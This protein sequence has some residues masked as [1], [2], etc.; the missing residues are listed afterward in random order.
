MT[1]MPTILIADDEQELCDSLRELLS[2]HGYDIHTANSG[3]EAI[4]S[5]NRIPYDLVLLDVLM[6]DIDGFRVME[7]IHRQSPG[8]LVI[9]ITGY[10]STESAIEALKRGAHYYIRKPFEREELLKAVQNALEK[11]RLE[12]ERKKAEEALKESSEKVKLFAYSISHDLKSPIIGIYGLTKLLHQNYRDSFDERGKTYCDQI[13]KISEQIVTLVNKINTYI[14][15]RE[16]TL[17]IENVKLKEILQIV[18]EEFSTQLDIRQIRWSEPI[19]RATIRGDRLSILRVIRNL[20]DNALKYGGS[21]LSRIS[22]GYRESTEFHIISVEDDGIGIKEEDC[23]KIFEPFERN[24]TS[25]GIEG[26]GLG[27]AIVKEIVKQHGGDVWAES[28]QEQG[29]TFHM[30]ISKCL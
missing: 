14:S 29:M 24:R 7:H 27:L 19:H 2:N 10:A 23:K 16:N 20:V 12:I 9:I 3:Y 11:R 21:D 26:A 28:N 6:P 4:E 5:L 15:S 8:T 13:L 17:T 30:S 1:F 18:K 25:K 22:I